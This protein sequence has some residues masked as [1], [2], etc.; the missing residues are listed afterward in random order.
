MV[1]KGQRYDLLTGKALTAVEPVRSAYLRPDVL[2]E[3]HPNALRFLPLEGG[4]G[5]EL[6]LPGKVSGLHDSRGVRGM[7]EVL[8]LVDEGD[9]GWSLCLAS[10]GAKAPRRLRKGPAGTRPLLRWAAA[11]GRTL[12]ALLGVVQG[13]Q[14]RQTFLRV[15]L[16]E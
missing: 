3:P 2:V 6:R 13:K 10:P 15:E 5:Q 4:R 11:E 7:N 14:E 1:E 12:Y 16:G 9:A 8:V